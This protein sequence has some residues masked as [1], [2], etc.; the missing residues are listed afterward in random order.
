VGGAVVLDVHATF[1]YSLIFG[2]V[3]CVPHQALAKSSLL[4]S[5]VLFERLLTAPLCPM[6]RSD[7]ARAMYNVAQRQTLRSKSDIERLK[8]KAD[9][10][11]PMCGT[12]N[13]T[14]NQESSLGKKIK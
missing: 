12:R 9:D 5:L 4:L 2:L 6:M 11:S 14:N 7:Q 13:H 3:F 8:Y 1:G 10:P